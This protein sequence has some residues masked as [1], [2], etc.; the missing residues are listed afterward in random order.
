MFLLKRYFLH[1]PVLLFLQSVTVE[2]AV[3]VIDVTAATDVAEAMLTQIDLAPTE[4]STVKQLLNQE[5]VVLGELVTINI[6]GRV[7]TSRQA[8]LRI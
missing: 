6:K 7:R 3:K 2:R 1:T 4:S 8:K 5:D